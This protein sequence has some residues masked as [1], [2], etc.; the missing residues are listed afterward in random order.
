MG[1]FMLLIAIIVATHPPDPT[2]SHITG[3]GAAAIAMTYAEAASY[4]LSWGPATWYVKFCRNLRA[5]TFR[6]VASLPFFPV[7]Q[8][9]LFIAHFP[10]L[11]LLT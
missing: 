1:T 2:S 7:H 10:A 4:N 11:A 3:A 8:L 9:T 6:L 5:L